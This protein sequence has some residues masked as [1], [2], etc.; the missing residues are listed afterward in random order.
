MLRKTVLALVS[1][2]AL[3]LSGCITSGSKMDLAPFETRPVNAPFAAGAYCNLENEDGARI[4]RSQEECVQVSWDSQTRRYTFAMADH[5][6][7]TR[8]PISVTPLRNGMLFAQADAA[9]IA[10]LQDEPADGAAGADEDTPPHMHAV[11]LV[12]G[13]AMLN[14]GWNATPEDMDAL[15]ARHPAIKLEG[16]GTS[17]V[18]AK[19]SR[20]D[21]LDYVWDLL[22]VSLGKDAS[23]P[24]ILV[25]DRLGAA[26]HA[27]SKAQ[28]RDI[29]AALEKVDALRR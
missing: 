15:A 25:R 24:S 10:K 7:T 21:A 29:R 18:I 1:I 2:G 6:K 11:L 20:Q 17:R 13:S 28:S 8:L 9:D 26:N 5:G 4:V 19:G 12:V 23:A 22:M 27:P 14:P 16:R 3:G